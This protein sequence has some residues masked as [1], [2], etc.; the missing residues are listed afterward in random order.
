MEKEKISMNS[1]FSG[2][3]TQER[4]IENT[5]CYDLTVIS[6]SEIDRD[7]IIAYAAIHKD[8][9]PEMAEEY[10][11]YP[12]M[13][14]I[15]KELAEKNI[16]YNP[17]N[18]NPLGWLDRAKEF[19]LKSCW[20]ACKLTNN[21]GDISK[22]EALPY[23]DLWTVSFPCQDISSAGG[24]KGFRKD[25]GT[26][27]SLVWEQLRLL[28]KAV[29]D[30]M[31]PKYLMF[32]NSPNIL[33]KFRKEF[34]ELRASLSDLGYNSYADKIRGMDCGI[35]QIRGRAFVI[36]IRKDI[37]SG[38]PF[39]FPQPFPL[40]CQ[41]EDFLEEDV[42]EKY[43]IK[44]RELDEFF[45]QCVEAGALPDPNTQDPIAIVRDEKWWK[46]RVPIKNNKYFDKPH[47]KGKESFLVGKCREFVRKNGFFP[48][49]IVPDSKTHVKNHVA[50]T[51]LTGCEKETSTNSMVVLG[52]LPMKDKAD[53][54]IHFRISRRAI[55]NIG[56]LINNGVL[57]REK[58]IDKEER[59]DE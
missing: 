47:T 21:L 32:E 43:Y 11:D 4:G 36:C 16:G 57:R 39:S 48:H 31:A 59:K 54:D 44:S 28:E 14:E 40:E 49:I 8:F 17:E 30:G 34:E 23:A 12:S 27:S 29:D 25:S 38:I 19:E 15:K 41:L 37:D 26:R 52:V 13:E 56:R 18:K 7:A 22:I 1:L 58:Y 55:E 20:L 10:S 50:R 35:P 42:D 2:I 51:L 33:T 53:Q 5:G 3:G 6:T 45:D 24:M 46:A 9:T